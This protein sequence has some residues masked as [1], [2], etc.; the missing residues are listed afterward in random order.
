MS[1]K[2]N[3]K[4]VLKKFPDAEIFQVKNI[5]KVEQND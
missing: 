2:P 1:R 4:D 5:N 3:Y